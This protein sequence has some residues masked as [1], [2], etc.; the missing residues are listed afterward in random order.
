MLEFAGLKKTQVDKKLD[1]QGGCFWLTN[2]IACL[3]GR[4]L[5]LFEAFACMVLACAMLQC[6]VYFW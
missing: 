1:P 6:I 4:Y 2:K 3:F 5:P